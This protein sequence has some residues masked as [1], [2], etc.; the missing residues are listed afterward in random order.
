M[1]V[2]VQVRWGKALLYNLK[3]DF[4]RCMKNINLYVKSG[5]LH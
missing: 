3:N 2:I 1:A 5:S 4:R